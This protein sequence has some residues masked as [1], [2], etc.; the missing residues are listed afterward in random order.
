MCPRSCPRR[1]RNLHILVLDDGSSDGTAQVASHHVA[2]DPRVQLLLGKGD[3]PPGWLGKPWACQR[4]SDHA[5]AGL[6]PS[7]LVFVDADVRL[8]PRALAAS[9]ELLRTNQLDLVSPYPRQEAATPAERLVQPLLQ[10]SWLTFLPLR[11]AERSKRPSLSAANGQLL[12]VDSAA[13]ARVGGH[14]SVSD[15]VVEDVALM[16]ALK[17]AGC[18]GVV[19]DGTRLASC[20]MYQDWPAVRD[21]YSKSLWAAFGST[22]GAALVAAAL[23][24]LYVVPPVAALRGSRT[25]LVGFAAA[26]AGRAA[27]ARRVDSRAWPDSIAHP[28]SIA[29]LDLLIVRS[30]W[31][32]RRGSLTWKGRSVVPVRPGAR[33]PGQDG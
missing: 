20:R 30:L 1:S 24:L 31:F 10:W 4:L 14:A 33:P 28:V 5:V 7:V 19:V 29:L 3:P 22:P 8:E 32:R 11:A 21:G 9:I 26:V 6:G 25:G 2:A 13:Y 27:V 15:R 23:T 17:R 16:A 12:V 18:R